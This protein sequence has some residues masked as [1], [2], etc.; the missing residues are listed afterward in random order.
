MSN[1][2]L[3]Y[4]LVLKSAIFSG[5]NFCESPPPGG[6]VFKTISIFLYV[7]AEIFVRERGAAVPGT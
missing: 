7:F 4:F 1:I 5:L 3:F 6:L 2:K